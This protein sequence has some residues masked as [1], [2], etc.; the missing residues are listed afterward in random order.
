M[1][2]VDRYG[3]NKNSI[4]VVTGNVVKYVNNSYSVMMHTLD[5]IKDMFKSK[6]GV[7]PSSNYAPDYFAEYGNAN[8]QAMGTHVDGSMYSNSSG[9]LATFKDP[10]TGDIHITYMYV[11]DTSKGVE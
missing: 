5:Q 8:M 10:V 2:L 6:Y 7:T 11:Y 1:Q 9:Y 3:N 4:L